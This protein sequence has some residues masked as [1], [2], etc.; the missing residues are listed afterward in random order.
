MD[1]FN[2][3]QNDSSVR[4]DSIVETAMEMTEWVLS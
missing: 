1:K 2:D 4:H 3:K